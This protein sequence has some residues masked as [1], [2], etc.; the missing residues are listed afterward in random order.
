MMDSKE[1]KLGEGQQ[2]RLDQWSNNTNANSGCC[3][4]KPDGEYGFV[5]LFFSLLE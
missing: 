4:S 5:R 3:F 1:V 2:N